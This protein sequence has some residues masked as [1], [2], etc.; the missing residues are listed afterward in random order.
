MNKYQPSANF[1]KFRSLV[2]ETFEKFANDYNVVKEGTPTKVESLRKLSTNDRPSFPAIVTLHE[3]GLNSN[4]YLYGFG[5]M[6]SASPRGKILSLRFSESFPESSKERLLWFILVHYLTE[7][8]FYQSNKATQIRNY[9]DNLTYDAQEL[10]KEIEAAGINYYWFQCK[11][12]ENI[13]YNANWQNERKYTEKQLM[14][15][16]AQTASRR[17]FAYV[18]ESI[19]KYGSE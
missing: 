9:L 18:A 3:L 2:Y 10:R 8:N 14:N 19:A 13:I 11:D 17:D 6:F 5:E 4:F 1:R 16:S 12:G 15:M 7:G